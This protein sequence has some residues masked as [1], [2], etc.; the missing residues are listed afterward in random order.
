MTEDLDEEVVFEVSVRS[1]LLVVLVIV[2]GF[3]RRSRCGSGAAQLSTR[4]VRSDQTG[5]DRTGSDHTGLIKRA[6]TGQ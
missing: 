5:L 1:G 2:L 3:E 6:N 4:T